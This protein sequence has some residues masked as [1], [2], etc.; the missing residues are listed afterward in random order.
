[1]RSYYG[2]ELSY[3]VADVFNK[4]YGV[5]ALSAKLIDKAQRTVAR[6]VVRGLIKNSIALT[7]AYFDQYVS[8]TCI[9]SGSVCFPHKDA[10]YARVFNPVR[11]RT[12]MRK[13]ALNHLDS[14]Y[15]KKIQPRPV[16]LKN[17][18]DQVDSF[19][20]LCNAFGLP[21]VNALI[22]H[23]PD[24]EQSAEARDALVGIL[25][26]FQQ[27]SRQYSNKFYKELNNLFV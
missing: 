7:A 20:H 13:S 6:E 9:H 2:S 10:F 3:A 11:I 5:L 8:A 15:A 24:I 16:Q 26:F 18:S 4:E 1:V 23:L 21:E 14:L 19:V 25:G 27:W 17:C 22:E 12:H